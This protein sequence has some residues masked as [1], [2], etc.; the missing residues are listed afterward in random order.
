MIHCGVVMGARRMYVFK[1]ISCDNDRGE[2]FFLD[3]GS[4]CVSDVIT[5]ICNGLASEIVEHI[6][7]FPKP[8]LAF[9]T[10]GLKLESD[11][12]WVDFDEDESVSISASR[13]IIDRVAKLL[14]ENGNFSG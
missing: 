1:R 4:G 14:I 6:D 11:T 5:V 12:I 7:I 10:K 2:L 8:G 3:Q 9:F 13:D